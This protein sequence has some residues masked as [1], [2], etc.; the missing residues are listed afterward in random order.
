MSVKQQM[1]ETIVSNAAKNMVTQIVTDLRNL[2][3]EQIAGGVAGGHYALVRKAKKPKAEPKAAPKPKKPV[4]RK[5]AAARKLQGS[6]MGF[7]RQFKGKV[8]DQ[9]VKLAKTDKAKAVAAMRKLRAEQAGK[10]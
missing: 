1:L 9:M 4:S 7:L 6:Y 3:L 8:R 2:T 10:R 5:Q